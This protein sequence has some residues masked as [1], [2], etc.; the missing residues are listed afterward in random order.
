MRRAIPLLILATLAA[1][2]GTSDL[3]APA[4]RPDADGKMFGPAKMRLHPVFTQVRDWTG[5]G[6]PDGIEAL[7]ELD[8]TFGDPTKAAG[9]VLFE[10][11]PY[12]P[13]D[14]NPRGDR[15]V[16]P[17]EGRLLSVDDQRTRW[18]RTSRTYTFQLAY[19]KISGSQSYVLTA[20]FDLAGG[21]RFFD[22]MI[23]EGTTPPDASTAP[24]TSDDD[25]P[26]ADAP[27]ADG[28]SSGPG[29]PGAP[30]SS[31]ASPPAGTQ[32]PSVVIPPDNK[33][34]VRGNQP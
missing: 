15:I 5:D 29:A 23:I 21:G 13:Y 9:T 17:W 30:P 11:Y 7:V 26:P 34:P 33:P 32:K 4:A 28:S 14:P 20:M 1:G 6:V 12:R 25:A 18:S 24:D 2:C 10:L 31:P 16:A 22:Q 3:L 8:D 27:P 19:P